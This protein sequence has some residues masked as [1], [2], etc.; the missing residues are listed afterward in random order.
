MQNEPEVMA[1]KKVWKDILPSVFTSTCATSSA[2]ASAASSPSATEM[3]LRRMKPRF[4]LPETKQRKKRRL[5][6][7][8]T[9]TQKR[10]GLFVPIKRVIR[11]PDGHRIASQLAAHVRILKFAK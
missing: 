1:E 10:V 3:S 5:M 2:M 6:E 11:L 9:L 8:N 4:S 7:S